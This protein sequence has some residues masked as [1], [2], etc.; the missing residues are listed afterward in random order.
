METALT[1]LTNRKSLLK[2]CEILWS[3]VTRSALAC[4]R[5][6]A[7]S[8][9]VESFD[10]HHILGRGL[11]IKFDPENGFCLCQDCH[12]ILTHG[13]PRGEQEL[14]A[15]I[16]QKFQTRYARLVERKAELAV[17][18]D[19]QA[20]LFALLAEIPRRGLL[21]DWDAYKARHLGVSLL[22]QDEA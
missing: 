15:W 21:R 2:K 13:T 18:F 6:K 8:D 9:S 4:G 1:T 3:F 12:R 5:C 22:F 11:S 16:E 10:A 19:P 14:R 17:S 7:R 20:Q